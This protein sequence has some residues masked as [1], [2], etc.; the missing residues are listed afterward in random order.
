MFGHGLSHPV[1]RRRACFQHWEKYCYQI[2]SV[3]KIRPSVCLPLVRVSLLMSLSPCHDSLSTWSSSRFLAVSTA[4]PA[5]PLPSLT[6]A[7]C[8]SAAEDLCSLSASVFLCVPLRLCL[9]VYQPLSVPL[10]VFAPVFVVTPII[11]RCGRQVQGCE[12]ASP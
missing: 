5:I 3:P 12:T 6:G 11:R 2:L 7:R 8:C 1:D 4:C 10:N 9:C